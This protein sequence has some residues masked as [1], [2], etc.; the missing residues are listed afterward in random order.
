MK[1]LSLYVWLIILLAISLVAIVPKGH[2]EVLMR[3]QHF[4]DQKLEQTGKQNDASQLQNKDKLPVSPE[5]QD[6]M[7]RQLTN[8]STNNAQSD[9]LTTFERIVKYVHSGFVH[10]I[11][12]GIDHILFVLGLFLVA[13]TMKQLLLQVTVFTL[14]HSITLGLA[15]SGYIGLSS[16]IVEPL[17]ALSIAYI[18]YENI[19]NRH[20]GNMRLAIIFVFGLLHGLGFA[21]VLQEFGVPSDSFL[22]ALFAFNIGVELGQ[23][24][25]I[26]AAY[27]LFYYWRHKP[28]Y[29]FFV[30]VP[31][32]IFIGLI[33]VYWTIERLV[34]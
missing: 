14:S 19:A 34:M 11:P 32:S 1:K 24:S 33:G 13:A 22:T 31:L 2:A 4:S 23:L 15:A 16:D 27:V 6:A 20:S 21:F 25:V 29:R 10:I 17:I 18:A 8:V 30:Q 28:S 12:M 7:E 3:N 5:M 9:G 26:A